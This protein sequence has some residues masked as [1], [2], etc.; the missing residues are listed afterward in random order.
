MPA[1]PPDR[2]WETC[3]TMNSPSTSL[4][5]SVSGGTIN[6]T[7][8]TRAPNANDSVVCVEVSGM[9]AVLADGVYRLVSVRSGKA[10]D[11]GNVS[12]EG[13]TVIQWSDNGGSPQKRTLTKIG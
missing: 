13:S 2:P 12:T 11:N 8:P 10:L 7:V 4:S 5:Y 6:V 3:A 9:P 1:A